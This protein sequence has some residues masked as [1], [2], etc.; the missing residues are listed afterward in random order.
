MINENDKETLKIFGAHLRTLREGKGLSLRE[1]S[2]AC[3]VDFSKIGLMEKGEINLTLLT[4]LDL[5][6]GLDIHP[7][8]LLNWK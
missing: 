4:I 5:A 2:Y 8:E 6:K 3:N 1:L 7:S